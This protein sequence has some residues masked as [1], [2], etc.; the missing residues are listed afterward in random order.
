MVCPSFALT[1]GGPGVLVNEFCG[2]VIPTTAATERQIEN[3][4]GEAMVHLASLSDA[5]RA[6][7]SHG[8]LARAAHWSWEKLTAAVTGGTCRREICREEARLSK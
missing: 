8:A 2:I 5:E 1:S 3:A 4:I 7:L 6:N